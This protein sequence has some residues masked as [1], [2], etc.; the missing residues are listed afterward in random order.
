MRFHNLTDSALADLL[1]LADAACKAAGEDLAALKDEFRR[2]GLTA[3]AGESFQVKESRFP[4]TR[5]D[6]AALRA[7]FGPALAPYEITAEASRLNI[8]PRPA[9]LLNAAA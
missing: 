1:G 4:Q 5:I 6:T 7:A 8:K 2:R 9:A 3:A